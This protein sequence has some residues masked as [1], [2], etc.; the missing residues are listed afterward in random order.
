VLLVDVDPVGTVSQALSLA[1]HQ[2]REPLRSLG[3]DLHGEVCR[4]V[5]AGLDV[6]SP[7]DEGIG[8]DDKLEKLLQFLG[9]DMI[10]QHYQCI[11]L[12][13]PPFIGERPR[14]LLKCCDEIVLVIRAEQLAFRTL[15]LFLEMVK[16]MSEEDGIGLRGI[17]LTLPE[18]GRWEVDLRRYLGTKALGPTIPNDP[19]VPRVESAGKAIAIAN[20]Q[21]PA[22]RAFFALSAELDLARDLPLPTLA[23]AG[24]QSYVAPATPRFGTLAKGK[25][26]SSAVITRPPVRRD[27]QSPA[28]SDSPRPGQRS[29]GPDPLSPRHGGLTPRGRDGLAGRRS[30]SSE[31]SESVAPASPI[32]P[33][34]PAF[35]QSDEGRLPSKSFL[36]PW[37]LWI[38]AGV[39]FG[40]ILG[41]V[42]LPQNFVPIAVG[43]AT[44][45]C[46]VLVLR[47]LLTA[48]KDV[49]RNAT[50]QSADA[51]AAPVPPTAAANPF[52]DPQRQ[53]RR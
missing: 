30:G 36:R 33:A 31:S 40:A 34:A 17:L 9:S 41:T 20:A 24:H 25:A 53:P 13:A 8:S 46:V 14:D 19:E 11:I 32:A 51:S 4:D 2:C 39:I 43:L 47:L 10:R 18:E 38:G 21:A 3:F 52:S 12:N 28:H 42:R 5:V 15:P 26:G 29:R 16:T 49:S 35:I 7:Y 27:A 37:H 44:G 50:Q 23:G 6:I 45:A 48:D 1:S 22:A